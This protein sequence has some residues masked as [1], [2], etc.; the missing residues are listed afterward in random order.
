MDTQM[1][2]DI[3]LFEKPKPDEQNCPLC[4]INLHFVTLEIK[5]G[6][7]GKLLYYCPLCHAI[8]TKEEVDEAYERLYGPLNL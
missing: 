3:D 6:V 8:L 4:T 5:P 7:D 2:N 1:N